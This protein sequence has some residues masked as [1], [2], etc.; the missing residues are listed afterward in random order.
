[1]WHSHMQ[2][3]LKYI[4]DCHRLVG[5]VIYHSPW[6][7]VEDSAMQTA[8]TKTNQIWKDEFSNDIETDHL[9]NT[10]DQNADWDW[11]E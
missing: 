11:D 2:E 10:I 3:P 8:C 5:Y 4:A 1:M 7:I 9:Y 6:P